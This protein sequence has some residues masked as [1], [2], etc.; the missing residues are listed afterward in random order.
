MR[1]HPVSEH[2]SSGFL[3]LTSALLHGDEEETDGGGQQQVHGL[4]QQFG[5]EDAPYEE[6]VAQSSHQHDVGCSRHRPQ[7]GQT[8]AAVAHCNRAPEERRRSRSHQTGEKGWVT[9]L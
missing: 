7:Q 9:L 2:G 8:V 1:G 4:V 5:R 6:M 3:R